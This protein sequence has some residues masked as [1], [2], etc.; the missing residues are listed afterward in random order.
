MQ[1][2]V[3]FPYTNKELSDRETEEI[4]PF[5]MASKRIRFLGINLP[6][7]RSDLYLEIYDT[8]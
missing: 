1:K 3:V 4:I 2:S 5:K 8:E 6:K 7:R